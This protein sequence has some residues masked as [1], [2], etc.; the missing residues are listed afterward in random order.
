MWNRDVADPIDQNMYGTHPFYLEHRLNTSSSTTQTHGVFLKSAAGQDILLQTPSGAN[1][2]LVQYRLIGGTLDLYFFSGPSPKEVIQQYGQTVG[3][4]AW[5]PMWALGFHLCRW[6]Y[7]NVS[8]TAANVVA[9][10]E[11]NIPL[12]SE[13]LC[14]S[15]RA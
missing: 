1:T 15:D 12:E 9:M 2:S 8:E 11:A 7:A 14:I 5:M 3:L 4:P 13:L 6:G 10:R